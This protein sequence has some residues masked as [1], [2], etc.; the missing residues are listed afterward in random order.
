MRRTD[1]YSCCGAARFHPYL[2]GLVETEIG[3]A[4]R[5]LDVQFLSHLPSNAQAK[6]KIERFFRFLQEQVLD[7]NQAVSLEE[8][9]SLADR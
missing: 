2:E 5:E 6:G 3:R 4:L 9:Q 1:C 8:L 7:H